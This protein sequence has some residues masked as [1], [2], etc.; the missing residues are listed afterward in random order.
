MGLIGGKQLDWSGGIKLIGATTFDSDVYATLQF[1]G[2]TDPTRIGS[3]G[4]ASSGNVNIVGAGTTVGLKASAGD[5]YLNTYNGGGSGT[6]GQGLKSDGTNIY[7]SNIP[8][9]ATTQIQFNNAGALA[10]TA[11]FTWWDSFK[12]LSAGY[13]SSYLTTIGNGALF[14]S[15][16]VYGGYGQINVGTGNVVAG[17]YLASTSVGSDVDFAGGYNTLLASKMY[18]STGSAMTVFATQNKHN[19]IAA[20]YN[21]FMS[22]SAATNFNSIIA[23]KYAQ[24]ATGSKYSSIISGYYGVITGGYASAIFGGYQH[25]LAGDYNAIVGG[26]S[27]TIGASYSRSAVIGGNGI[28]A[29][30]SDTVFLPKIK[31]GLGTG[32]S[33]PVED[34]PE[35]A[36]GYDST[37]GIVATMLA[38][39]TAKVTLTQGQIQSLNTTPIE[40]IAAPGANKYI[41]VIGG[42][43]NYAWNSTSYVLSGGTVDNIQLSQGAQVLFGTHL[44]GGASM[45]VNPGNKIR[46]FQQQDGAANTAPDIGMNT[47]IDIDS[48]SDYTGAGGTID[49]YVQYVVIDTA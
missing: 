2:K 44:T 49:V 45:I 47:A 27:G 30:A 9:G 21:A 10:G 48:L 19:I 12:S 22:A 8:G 35:F 40:I 17:N 43:A 11:D 34:E 15:G 3:F 5:M 16:Y 6:V 25:T 36:L 20:S 1:G 33:L 31:I 46:H 4:I 23:S 14:F 24:I 28:T 38:V 29:D 18:N 26:A 42:S 7:W 37:T 39:K 41:Q 13:G 32:G